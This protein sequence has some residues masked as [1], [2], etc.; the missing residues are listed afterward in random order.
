[1][2]NIEPPT[3]RSCSSII[4]VKHIIHCQ[5][6]AEAGKEYEIPDNLYEA[7]GPCADTERIIT[8]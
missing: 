7:I 8:F 2:E 6:F 1:M 5:I 3:C 4:S